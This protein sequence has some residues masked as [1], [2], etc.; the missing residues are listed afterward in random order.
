MKKITFLLCAGVVML[1]GCKDIVLEETNYAPNLNSQEPIKKTEIEQAQNIKLQPQTRAI[2]AQN[3]AFSLDFFKAV[4][5]SC[6]T[7]LFV[8]PF[9][10]YAA[11]GMLYNGAEGETK[12]EIAE[13]LRMDDYTPLQMNEYYQELTQA[14]LEVDPSTSLSL[15]NA[16]WTNKGYTLQ[17]SF[18]GL[19]QDY[20]DARISTLDFSHPSAVQTIN[21]WCNEQTKGTIPWIVGAIDPKT[22]VI[23]ANAIYFQSFWTYDF[24]PSKTIDKPF[25]NINGATATVPM[26]HQKELGLWYAQMD[27]CGMVTL[28]Y[29]NTAFAMNLILPHKGVDVDAVINEL[30]AASWQAIMAHR[31]QTKVTLSMPRFKVENYLE[32][33]T[34]ILAALG[35]PSAFS[36]FDADFS[37]MVNDDDVFISEVIQ[38][39]YISVDEAGTEAAAVTLLSLQGSLGLQSNPKEVTMVVDRPFMFAITEQ[40]TGAI[41]FMGKVTQL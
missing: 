8:S 9:S 21:D 39:S 4:S 25:Y 17:N 18:V 34:G 35:M 37:A 14:L 29:A 15:A 7:N 32:D 24:D 33:L 41:L 5:Q 6:D 13:V 22:I 28:P 16:I 31:D 10:M 12:K 26:M 1:S 36:P 19:N 20:Y 2:L 40:S 27:D 11:L 23:L 38:K 30:D 3:N